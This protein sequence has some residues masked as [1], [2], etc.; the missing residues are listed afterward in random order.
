MVNMTKKL[1]RL[2]IVTIM[3]LGSGLS[4][5]QAPST[6]TVNPSDFEYVM[7][8]TAVLKVN[9]QIAGENSNVV[10]AF[11]ESECRGKAT[12]LLTNGQQ[13]YFLMIYG[14]T[15]GE[16]VTVKTYYSPLDTVL[17]N[18]GSL[19]FDG[20]AAYGSPDNPYEFIA[21][22]TIDGIIS[23]DVSVGQA[24]KLCQNYPNPFNTT[25][26]ISY[27]I[28]SPGQVRL[29]IYDIT[30]RTVR[31]LVDEYQARGSYTVE[32]DAE[33]VSSGLY[34]YHLQLN[35]QSLTRTCISVK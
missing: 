4:L 10:A 11:V 16:A 7:T 30:G 5:A 27:T 25:T 8:V 26:Q 23:E 31:M 6:W 2:L 20:T 18:S 22:Y 9:D 12:P 17:N 15:N 1:I 35:G 21:T 33:N 3:A 29:T 14:N 34:H 24:F 32:W 28:A 19:V 13:M